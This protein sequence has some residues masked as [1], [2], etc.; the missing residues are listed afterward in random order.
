MEKKVT[1]I[2]VLEEDLI[3][4]AIFDKKLVKLKNV[5]NTFPYKPSAGYYEYNTIKFNIGYRFRTPTGRLSKVYSV[6]QLQIKEFD[7]KSGEVNWISSED[8]LPY[9]KD[10]ISRHIEA[11]TNNL[12]NFCVYHRNN[13]AQIVV[14]TGSGGCDL[15]IAKDFTNKS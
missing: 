3:M 9:V 5:K 15:F 14:S 8:K 13:L 10:F 1:E 7:T 11:Y 12:K 2:T 4:E 6:H